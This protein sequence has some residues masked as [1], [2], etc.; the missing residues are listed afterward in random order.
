M[1]FFQYISIIYQVDI[2]SRETDRVKNTVY[3]YTLQFRLMTV[4]HQLS[5]RIILF[6]LVLLP[7]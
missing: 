7:F 5:Y 3:S 2:V 4:W 6:L 1:L